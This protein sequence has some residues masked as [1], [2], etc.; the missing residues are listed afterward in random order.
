[1]MNRLP[2]P[3][4]ETSEALLLLLAEDPERMW[5]G[6]EI[7]DALALPIADVLMT[8]AALAYQGFVACPAPGRYAAATSKRSETRTSL[9]DRC[10]GTI[11]V[12]RAV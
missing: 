1:M 5:T 8:A 2:G 10:F 6:T 9:E 3:S 7:V 12:R 4:E 11:E